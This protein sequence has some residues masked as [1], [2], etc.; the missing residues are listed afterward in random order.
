MHVTFDQGLILR[1]GLPRSTR[2]VGRL[3]SLALAV[4]A[5]G[6]AAAAVP[7]SGVSAVADDDWLGI[8]NTYR[9]MSGLD[10]VAANASWSADAV[11][12]SCYMLQNGITHDET[13]GNPGYTSGGDVAGNSG[14]VAVSSSVSSTPRNHIEL[15]MTGPFHA[16]GVLRH[17]LRSSGY[18]LC[19]NADTS[20]WR[21]AGTLDVLRGLDSTPR[22]AHAV[23]F[24]GNGATVPLHSFITESPNPLTMCGWTGAAGLPLI[25]MLPSDVNAASATLSGPSGPIPTCVL[26][27]GN[28]S[29]S[30]ARSILDGDNAVIVMPRTPLAD[31]AYSV[32]VATNGGNAD[33]TFNVDRNAPLGVM[34]A[35]APVVSVPATPPARFVPVAPFRH[36]DSRL[37]LRTVR[38]IGGQRAEIQ[39]TDNPNYVAVSANFVT[40]DSS[41][42]GHLTTYNCTA[43]VPQVSTLGYRPGSVVA[44]QAF[45]PLQNGKICLYSLRDTDVVVDIN[46]YYET[47]S[48]GSG[49]TPVVP[50]RLY[51][52]RTAND[53]LYPGQ[54]RVLK[55]SG[56]NPGAPAGSSAVALTLT[57]IQPN[58][59]SFMRVY[60]C[61]VDASSISSINLT[62]NEVR[63][64]TVVTPVAADGTVCVQTSEATHFAVDLSGYFGS[65]G[66]D[67]QPFTPVRVF[68]SRLAASELNPATA[69]R[70]LQGGVP[71]RL[72]IA[73]KQG[74]PTNAKAASIN[75]TVVDVG[76]PTFVTVYP[77]GDLPVASNVNI[78]P[79]QAVAANGAMAKLSGDG[80]LCLYSL[81]PVH[82][83]V[84]ING[85]WK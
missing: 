82:V 29:D 7:S 50:I 45:V 3:V 25:A 47:G 20:P 12:H 17:N 59:F 10:P 40:V 62:P 41:S 84:D 85:V 44:N 55:V 31:G 56:V 77:C 54:E 8:V 1:R 19:A 39:I 76:Y 34:P 35:P 68:D 33:W 18:G 51:D 74:V 36:V 69:G 37:N 14:N 71:I 46:G 2:T 4:G 43:E 42:A 60:P 57:G 49:Y 32:S 11:N 6:F 73:G 15:W 75:I 13:P 22:P 80:D 53:V 30:T 16:I 28:V 58:W 70:P 61:G 78:A 26:H 65:T 72:D 52:S 67:F 66:Y 9:A 81:N 79:G 5:I 48:H 83:V 24:P 27:K 21:S 63:A 38:L 64:N 23:V